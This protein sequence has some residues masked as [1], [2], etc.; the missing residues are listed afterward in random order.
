MRCLI[1]QQSFPAFESYGIPP[2]GGRC[3]NCG[4][5]PRH[6]EL[7]WFFQTY[8]RLKKESK[9]LEV[10][11]S[12]IQA[13]FF[14]DPVYIG[15]AKYTGIDLLKLKHHDLLKPPH[16]FLEMDVTRLSFSDQSFD[17]ILCNHVLPFIRSDYMAMSE[18][19]RCLK[20]TGIAVLNVHIGLEKTKRATEMAQIQPDLYTE[21]FRIENGTEWVYGEDFFERLEAAGFFHTRIRLFELASN[22]IRE[23]GAFREDSELFCCFKFQDEM[24]RF[25]EGLS[26]R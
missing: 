7:A 10:G 15:E 3:P 22:E 24:H 20:S 17:V 26:H 9:I 5:K 21:E 6:R 23:L 12:K 2:R 11:P 13:K 25:K 19:H 4:S 8:V 1:C 18:I 14:V 16:R